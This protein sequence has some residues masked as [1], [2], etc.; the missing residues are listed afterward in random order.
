M[1]TK[2]ILCDRDG[3]LIVDKHYLFNPDEI[4]LLPTVAEGIQILKEHSCFIAI[5]SNQSGVGR[6]Y[7]TEHDVM[8][9]NTKTVEL[10]EHAGGGID[11]IAY[12]P[13]TPESECMCRKPALGM[14]HYLQNTYTLDPTNT[15]MIGDKKEDI[16]FAI[17]AQFPFAFLVSTGKGEEIQRAIGSTTNKK[18]S[19]ITSLFKNHYALDTS[20]TTIYAVDSFIN[21]TRLLIAL[22]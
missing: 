4:E 19:N 7:F 16:E 10:L 2:T 5:V 18:Y 6:G 21:C 14:W 3:T 20:N 12:C 11:A 1:K 8:L 17:H 15:V 13:H 9:C 22:Q